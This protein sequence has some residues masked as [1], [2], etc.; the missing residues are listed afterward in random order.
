MGTSKPQ[1]YKG[2]EY[3]S[4]KALA[5]ELGIDRPNLIYTYM[6]TMSLEDAIKASQEYLKNHPVKYICAINGKKFKTFKSIA[7]FVHVWQ[8]DFDK[9][10]RDLVMGGYSRHDALV[11]TIHTFACKNCVRVDTIEVFDKD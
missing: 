4:I 6:K 11:K 9:L 7:N 1:V 3:P 5:D 8:M 10:R 2:K